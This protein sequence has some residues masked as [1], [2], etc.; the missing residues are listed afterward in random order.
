MDTRSRLPHDVLLHVASFADRKSILALPT[1]TRSLHI[2]CGKYAL[3]DPVVLGGDRHIAS[4]ISFMRP[5]KHQRWRHLRTLHLRGKPISPRTAEALAKVIP[6]AS[7][8]TFL[9]FEHAERTLGAHPDLPLA[10]AALG[11]IK[12]IVIDHGSQHTCR[13]LEA[14]HWPLG[15]AVLRHSDHEFDPDYLGRIHPAALLKNSRGTIKT[16]ENQL[17]SD[18]DDVLDTHPVYPQMESLHVQS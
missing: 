8:L 4:F 5:H 2:D 9:E 6:Y 3:Q 7:H 13:M 11:A 12:G 1:T 17:W 16:L 15:S 18:F 14:M 10:F